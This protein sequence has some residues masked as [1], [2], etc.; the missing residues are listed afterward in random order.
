MTTWRP[1]QRIRVLAIGLSWHRGRLLACDVTDDAGWI[2][3]VRPP[4]G[5][6]NFGEGWQ[7]ALRRE[8]REEFSLDIAITGAPVILENIFVHEGQTGHEIVFA[9]PITGPETAFADRDEVPFVEDNGVA[10]TAR[11]VDPAALAA[12][13]IPLFPEGLADHLPSPASTPAPDSP[14]SGT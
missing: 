2:K 6:V 5:G 3:G 10:A 14:H 11:W 7:D 8:F 13:G 12:D 4:G 1:R 9:A